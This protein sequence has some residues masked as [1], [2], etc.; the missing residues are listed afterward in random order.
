[1]A[2]LAPSIL[3]ADLLDLKEEVL[4]VE[5]NGADFIHV[6]VMDGHYVP[7]IAFGPEIVH[8]LSR[9]TKLPIDVHLMMVEPHK[10]IINFANAGSSIITV[11]QEVCDHLDRVIRH[12]KENGCRAGVS[13]NPA[14]PVDS[15]SHILSIVDLVLIMTV[16]PGFGGQEFISYSIEKI[17]KLAKT[18]SD[19]NYN[20]LIEVDG[21]IYIDNVASILKAG[22][23]VIVT[24]SGIFKQKNIAEACSKFKAILNGK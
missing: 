6:D 11:H 4:L 5:Q 3:A 14:T 18:K 2:Y 7:N 15:L 22:A 9:V 8:A 13:I 19:N 21:G 16:N 12:I 10:H 24:G 23:E 17:Q 20:F 1:M